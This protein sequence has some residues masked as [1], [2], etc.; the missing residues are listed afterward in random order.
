MT[1]TTKTETKATKATQSAENSQGDYP[2]RL[3]STRTENGVR[4]GRYAKLRK[5]EQKTPPT[6][7]TNEN[8][9]KATERGGMGANAPRRTQMVAKQATRG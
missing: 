4:R 7:L 1:G 9:R 5:T 2:K 3:G 8:D 6:Q